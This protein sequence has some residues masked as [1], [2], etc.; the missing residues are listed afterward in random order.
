MSSPSDQALRSLA[1]VRTSRLTPVVVAIVVAIVAALVVAGALK[2]AGGSEPLPS[3]MP[4]AESVE[5]EPDAVEQ[6]DAE[7]DVVPAGMLPAVTYEIFLARDP[8]EPVVPEV[9]EPVADQDPTNDPSDPSDP[10]S[11]AD[12][13]DGTPMIPREPGDPRCAGD[14]ELVCDGRVITLLDVT[15]IGEQQVAVIQVDTTIHE[16]LVGQTFAD[17]LEVR[18][19]DGS[20]VTIAYGDVTFVIRSGGSVLK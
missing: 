16:V 19:I 12:P 9:V 15:T 8:F 20:S 4:A 5:D 17:N 13:G 2:G 3:A 11:P 6:L 7:G 10:S 18:A 1:G 14:Q